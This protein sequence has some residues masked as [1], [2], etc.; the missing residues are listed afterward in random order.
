MY[1]MLGIKEIAMLLCHHNDDG[2]CRDILLG[3]KK[4]Q[5]LRNGNGKRIM[6]EMRLM[7]II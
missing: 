4:Q 3:K 6:I 5:P 7:Q 1:Y 2:S